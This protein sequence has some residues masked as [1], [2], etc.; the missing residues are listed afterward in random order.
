MKKLACWYFDWCS[1]ES[2]DKVEKNSYLNVIECSCTRTWNI[3]P[4]IWILFDIC[5]QSFVLS[6][7]WL[8]AYF[9]YIPKVFSF[10]SKVNAVLLNFKFQLIIAVIKESTWPIFPTILSFL[11]LLTSSRR[12]FLLTWDIFYTDSDV[13]C[14]LNFIFSLPNWYTFYFRLLL[15]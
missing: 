8:C 7:Y 12:F 14:K 11:K 3:F 2:I 15:Y 10:S 5:Y 1:I 9:V 6:S 4:F 13:I